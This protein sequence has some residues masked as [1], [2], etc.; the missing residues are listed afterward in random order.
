MSLIVVG[1]LT[2]VGRVSTPTGTFQD[3]RNVEYAAT[4]AVNL[5]I[6]NTRYTFD[7]GDFH[8]NPNV[9]PPIPPDAQQ[10]DEQPRAPRTR[11][12]AYDVSSVNV[13]CTMVWQAYSANTR[14]F[15][16]SACDTTVS[17]PRQAGPC[18]AQPL[19]QGIVAF[20][21]YPSGKLPRR[22]RSRAQCTPIFFWGTDSRWARRTGRVA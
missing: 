21:D 18:A 5:A 19:L 2:W 7:Y 8:P 11:C 14:L 13:Y 15:T 20:D 1:L 12:P 3:E 9:V 22:L 4:N 10:P 6:Q 16:N 17:P